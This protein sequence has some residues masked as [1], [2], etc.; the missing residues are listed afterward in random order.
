MGID[1]ILTAPHS[2]WQNPFAE[3]LIGS[4]R[5]ERLDHRA[6][7]HL[8]LDKDA[9]HGRPIERPELG[10][11]IPVRE[12]GGLPTPSQ[13][14]TG[15]LIQPNRSP[16]PGPSLRQA[17][18]PPH[19]ELH[20]FR[21]RIRM[22]SKRLAALPPTRCLSLLFLG[23]SG[24]RRPCQPSGMRFWRRTAF[25]GR[26]HEDRTKTAR[27]EAS[28]RTSEGKDG[29]PGVTRTPGTQFRKLLLYPPELRGHADL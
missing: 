20:C 25:G 1:E 3:R 27:R 11:V 26:P 12:V 17:A 10:R 9:P 15:G 22:G 14:P 7:T 2:P 4:I 18:P 13:R 8:S 19:L 21:S 6:R 23:L 5:R 24:Q 16:R 29:A 28:G